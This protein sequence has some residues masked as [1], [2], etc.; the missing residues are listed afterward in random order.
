MKIK[1]HYLILLAMLAFLVASC[2]KDNYDE[3]SSTLSGRLVYQ[4]ESIGVE[5]NQVPFEIYQFGF[6]KIGAISGT[7]APEGTYSALLFNGDYKLTIPGGQGPFIWNQTSNGTPDSLAVKLTGSQTL[8]LEVMPYF[9]IRTPN[10]TVTGTSVSA[11][12]KLEKIVNDANARNVET[13]RLYI[14]KTQFVSGANNV[15]STELA[16]SAITD[17][18]NV[19][20]SVNIPVIVPTQNYIFARI[21]VKISGVEDMIFSPVQKLT[22]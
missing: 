22:Y 9:M 4:G 8:D 7:F 16:G 12:F 6:G 17:P 14:N 11:T 3:P 15:G 20:L 13:V 10:I 1:F 2:K 18:D 21:G 5:F 19:T